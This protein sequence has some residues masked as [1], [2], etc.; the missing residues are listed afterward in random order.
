MSINKDDDCYKQ[1]AGFWLA[2]TVLAIT[3]WQIKVKTSSLKRTKANEVFCL[4]KA[5]SA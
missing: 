3:S 1:N 5:I 2:E 4:V